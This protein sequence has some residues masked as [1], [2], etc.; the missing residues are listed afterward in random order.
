[1]PAASRDP[2]G[3]FVPVYGFVI[4]AAGWLAWMIPFFIVRRRRV[5]AAAKD[6]RARWGIVLQALAYAVLWMN[7]WTERDPGAIRFA[8]A[9]VF[10]SIGGL[11][12]WTSV[13]ALGRQWRIDAGLNPDHELV[14]HGAY[15]IVRHPIYA[16]ML[17]MFLGTASVVAL[18]TLIPV[19]LI[20]FIAGT[21][22]RIRIED[23]L[24]AGRFGAE[25][26]AWRKQV[27]AYL[28]GIR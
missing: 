4:F 13:M 17:A 11:L 1:L 10:F 23:R 15:R 24:L 20:L 12:S 9:A 8:A 25:F 5:T 26:T 18:P 16:S 19:A 2:K 3:K 7:R 6:R 22:I 27:S 21:E 28:P 14:R